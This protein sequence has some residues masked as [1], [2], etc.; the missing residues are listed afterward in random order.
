[1]INNSSLPTNKLHPVLPWFLTLTWMA[2]IYWFSDQPNSSQATEHYLGMWNF[3]GRKAAHVTE[4]LIL[5]FLSRW[6]FAT[7]DTVRIPLLTSAAIFSTA[8][9]LVD[10]WHQ[11]FVIGRSASLQDVLIDSTGVLIG[12]SCFLVASRIKRIN[13]IKRGIAQAEAGML[14]KI[15]L[16]D[17]KDL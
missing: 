14:V 15:D 9:S 1:M 13:S 5:F 7:L 8:Y 17:D 11:S 12:L 4:Y 10:E 16:D 3:Y 6:S 2:V